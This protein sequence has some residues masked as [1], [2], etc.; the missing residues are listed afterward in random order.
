MK[1]MALGALLNGL[2]DLTVK[3]FPSI[4]Q[5]TQGHVMKPMALVPSL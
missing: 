5:G 2:G 4:E 3:T 1:P